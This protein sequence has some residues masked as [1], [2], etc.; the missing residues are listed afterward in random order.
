MA[1]SQL[2]QISL[3][4]ARPGNGGPAYTHHPAD[5]CIGP[6]ATGTDPTWDPTSLTS[7]PSAAAPALISA[8]TRGHSPWQFP[9]PYRPLLEYVCMRCEPCMTQHFTDPMTFPTP[10]GCKRMPP[11][12]VHFWGVA[13]PTDPTCNLFTTP[14]L[15]NRSASIL[16]IYHLTYHL[17][18]H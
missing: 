8:T 7:T 16:Y 2:I 18:H 14:L 17:R 11:F 10:L 12:G 13:D 15:N 9:P 4:R 6:F 3:R 1:R 5:L